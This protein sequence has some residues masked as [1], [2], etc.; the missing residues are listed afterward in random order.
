MKQVRLSGLWDALEIGRVFL[1]DMGK[2]S[3]SDGFPPDMLEEWVDGKGLYTR[4]KV[5]L[6]PD[7]GLKF[8]EAVVDRY[9][10]SSSIGVSAVEEV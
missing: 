6:K 10:G 1:D 5:Y 2:V 3:F 9:R 8:L 7:A 4:V